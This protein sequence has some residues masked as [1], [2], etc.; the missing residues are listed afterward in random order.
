MS[1]KFEDMDIFGI[2]RI[3][4]KVKV[5]T[6]DV[7]VA[8][9][10]YSYVGGVIFYIDPNADDNGAVYHFFDKAGREYGKE[11]DPIA[12]GDEP[13]IV[14]IEGTPTKDRYYVL[15]KE[16][17]TSK[18]WTYYENS[19]YVY[20]SL[21]TTNTIGSGKTNTALVMAADSGKYVTSDSNGEPTIWYQLKLLRDALTG[22]CSDWF[23][24]SQAEI[25]KL[26][27]AID[28]GYISLT[29]FTNRYIWSSAEYSANYAWRWNY[30]NQSWYNGNKDGAHSVCAVRAF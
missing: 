13:Y 30:G 8:D 20:N 6:L 26:K 28:N 17:F 23:I 16:L 7:T 14:R 24:P 22:G 29:W 11:L 1:V 3:G 18:R 25:E 9:P 5:C 27:L 2:S 15:H 10:E 4:R 19:E 12:I 21:G